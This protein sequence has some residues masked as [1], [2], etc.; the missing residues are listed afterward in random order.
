[1]SSRRVISCSQAVMLAKSVLLSPIWPEGRKHKLRASEVDDILGLL[2]GNRSC[3][4][5]AACDRLASR[6]ACMCYWGI[7]VHM[8]L[9]KEH[10][11]SKFAPLPSNKKQYMYTTQTIECAIRQ[12]ETHKTWPLEIHEPEAQAYPEKTNHACRRM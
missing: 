5:G 4:Y 6:M 11:K 9:K 8:T 12:L 2:V 1:M 3:L 7:F 10:R